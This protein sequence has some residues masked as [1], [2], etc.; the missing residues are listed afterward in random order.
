MAPV[1]QDEVWLTKYFQVTLSKNVVRDETWVNAP[2][3]YLVSIVLGALVVP[4]QRLAGR[5]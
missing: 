4:H 1:A 5:K 3:I 2:A